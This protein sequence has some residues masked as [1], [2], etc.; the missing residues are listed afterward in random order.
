MDTASSTIVVGVDGSAQADR[1]LAVAVDE[2]RRH[3]SRLEILLA[4][5]PMPSAVVAGTHEG[6]DELRARARDNLEQVLARAPSTEGLAV[7]ATTVPGEAARVLIEAS[8][9]ATVL[10]VGSRGLGGFSGLLLGSVST[11]CVHH[12]ACS[13]LVVRG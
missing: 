3:G 4:Y 9:H 13:V 10:V 11:K 6:L 5:A 7:E 2:A 12:A 1:A 8:R